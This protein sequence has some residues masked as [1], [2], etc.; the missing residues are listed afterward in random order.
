MKNNIVFLYQCIL[1]KT[2]SFSLT[3]LAVALFVN[4]TPAQ[5]EGVVQFGIGQALVDTDQAVASLYASDVRASSLYVDI[6]SAGEVINISLC[7]STNFDDLAVRIFA[8][9][10]DVNP[11]HT[12]GLTSSNVDCANTMTNPLANPITVSS[13]K[14]RRV[15]CLVPVFS[16]DTI[17]ELLPMKIP[18]QTQRS[19]LVG[20]GVITTFSMAVVFPRIMQPMQTS[21]RWF[22]PVGLTHRMFGS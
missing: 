8:P 6:L 1:R 17:L 10:D 16:N 4:T 14:T 2:K 3:C 11:I 13:Y 19:R 12:R 15:R 5:A 22:H 7:G 9:S 18:T 21:I 20:Y